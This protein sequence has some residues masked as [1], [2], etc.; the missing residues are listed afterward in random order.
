[1]P[2]QA[3]ADVVLLAHLGVVAFVV[4]GLV[5]IV[6]GNFTGWAWVNRLW[7]RMAH[8]LAITIVVAESWLGIT[9]PLTALEAWLRNLA[10]SPSYSQSFIEHWVQHLL[11]YDAPSWVFGGAYTVFGFLVLVVWWYYPPTFKAH[12]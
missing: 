9:C 2:Y 6:I 3:F 4:G 5:L 7:F 1:M 11:F 8:L 12:T 10:G